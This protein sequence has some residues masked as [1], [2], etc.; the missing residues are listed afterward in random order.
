MVGDSFDDKVLSISQDVVTN[1]HLLFEITN[2]QQG[3]EIGSNSIV[4]DDAGVAIFK[5]D[6]E[7]QTSIYFALFNA[8]HST[9]HKHSDDLSFVLSYGETDILLILESTTLLK[10]TLTGRSFEVSFHTILFQLIIKP[11]ISVMTISLVIHNLNHL[12]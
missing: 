7:N 4:Y 1:E 12:Q 5:N 10:A 9:V 8:F 11:T 2:G 3:V 6:W